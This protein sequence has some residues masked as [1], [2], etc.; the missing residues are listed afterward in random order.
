MKGVGKHNIPQNSVGMIVREIDRR[1]HLQVWSYVPG[2]SKSRRVFFAALEVDLNAP[3]LV[4]VQCVAKDCLILVA[5]MN[6]SPN[7]LVVLCIITGFE[8]RLWINMA[9]R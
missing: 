6:Q 5:G 3:L 2:E 9:M 8:K 4:N 7:K 1:I